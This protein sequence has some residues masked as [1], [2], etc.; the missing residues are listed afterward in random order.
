MRHLHPLGEAAILH[1]SEAAL[2]QAEVILLGQATWAMSAP[3]PRVD[4][5]GLADR[6]AYGVGAD[7]ATRA[8]IS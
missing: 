3:D 2:R 4:D 8:T 1:D 6:D 7:S 5:A